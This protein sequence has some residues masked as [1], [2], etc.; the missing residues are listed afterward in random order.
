MKKL[1]HRFD[2]RIG[3]RLLLFGTIM[4]VLP[5]SVLGVYD[6]Y[7]A[8]RNMN[9]VVRYHQAL[10]ITRVAG[11]LAG[12][13]SELE[14]SLEV[15]GA[16]DGGSLPTAGP[17]ERERIL[18]AAVARLPDMESLAAVDGTGKELARVSRRDV[19]SQRNLRDLSGAP[20]FAALKARRTYLGP[21]HVDEANQPV[22][23]L[24]VPFVPATD[25][26]PTGGLVATVSL[27][28]IV[29]RITAVPIGDG[30]YVFLV[31]GDGRLIGH[32]DFSQVLRGQDVRPSLP[33]PQTGRPPTSDG[34]PAARIY[35]SYT[36]EQVIGAHAPV[37]GTDWLV[38]TEQPAAIA[39]APF[40]TLVLAFTLGAGGIIVIVLLVSLF[41]GLRFGRELELLEAGVRRVASGD[42]S[43]E[44]PVKGDDE[45]ASVVRAFNQMSQELRAKR[46][47]EA[48]VRQADKQ[49]AVGL[50][51]AGVAHEIN[52]PLA[53]ISVS[54]EDLLD[55]LQCGEE[56]HKGDELPSY[57]R[58]I[59]D[60]AGRCAET[61]RKLL[62]FARQ[63]ESV[64]EWVDVNEQVNSTLSLL[65][66]RLRKERIELTLA[67][68]PDIPLVLAD[69]PGLQQVVFNLVTNAADAMA[70]GG[71]LTVSTAASDQDVCITIA[72][73]GCGIPPEDLPRIFEPFFTTKPV[74]RGT[75]LG[76]SVCFGIVSRAGGRI[77]VASTPGSGT[78]VAII[79]PL[80]IAPESRSDGHG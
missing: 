28:S 23:A 19:V 62:D 72:D 14:R 75:G 20:E 26:R 38:I 39:Y 5:L 50:L 59:R 31:D 18:Y 76:L 33:P 12:M 41:F 1:L 29:D 37:P 15:L 4:S 25:G 47:M 60:Q 68:A 8:R 69:G 32:E 11:D 61:T 40:R 52:N 30:G 3:F 13:V 21:V 78:Q 7:T 70:G 77:E 73:T 67:L 22:F 54:A 48:A 36:G 56:L 63:T 35:T 6:L 53:T 74:G 79:L 51:A 10:S 58:L 44:L 27:R 34:L 43:Q 45:L 42:L 2:R 55:R 80:R 66:Y 17:G 24:G 65:R 71:R 16:T 46:E 57:L 49:V 64:D 9:S